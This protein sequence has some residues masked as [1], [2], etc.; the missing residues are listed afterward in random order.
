M[1]TECVARDTQ[2]RASQS[3]SQTGA[4]AQQQATILAANEKPMQRDF[5]SGCRE[6]GTG[7][8]GVRKPIHMLHGLLGRVCGGTGVGWG[9]RKM[10][11]GIRGAG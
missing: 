6:V 5:N 11:L 3:P 4:D 10:N 9:G 7:Q 8:E 1:L 2:S